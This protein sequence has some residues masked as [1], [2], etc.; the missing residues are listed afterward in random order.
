[1]TKKLDTGS[2]ALAELSELLDRQKAAADAAVAREA[3]AAEA[4]NDAERAA[5]DARGHKDGPMSFE[6]FRAWRHAHP[7]PEWAL[8]ALA[9]ARSECNLAG[10]ETRSLARAFGTTAVAYLTQLLADNA[11]TLD[12]MNARYKRTLRL[13]SDS[14]PEGFRVYCYQ[15]SS[16]FPGA[17]L[18]VSD[19]FGAFNG[20]TGLDSYIGREYAVNANYEDYGS[21]LISAETL[22]RPNFVREP[23]ATPEEIRAQLDGLEAAKDAMRAANKAH[24]A[25]ASAYREATGALAG[26]PDAD[27]L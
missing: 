12:G 25:A 10:L 1:M 16:M 27:N 8:E 3:S 18:V 13:I 26:V 19:E 17:E 15:W 5:E 20:Y 11:A 6:E 24:A 9:S 14:M 7:T 4:V 2:E 22:R 21:E 23:G